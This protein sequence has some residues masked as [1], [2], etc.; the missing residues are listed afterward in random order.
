MD[1][2]IGEESGIRN[3]RIATVIIK[4]AGITNWDR[5]YKAGKLLFKSRAII[6]K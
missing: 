5:Y 6:T 2:S 4:W 3:K 1:D